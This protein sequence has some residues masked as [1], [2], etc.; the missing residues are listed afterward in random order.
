MVQLWDDSVKRLVRANPQQFF[1]TME[2]LAA[3][4]Q[5]VML[6]GLARVF[7]ELVFMDEADKEWLEKSFAVYKDIVDESWVVQE[8]KAEGEAKGLEKGRIEG[9]IE[10]K[11]E[12][13]IDGL[14]QA[15]L[16]IFQAR[17]PQF[18]VK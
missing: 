11:K 18:D 6:L 16:A 7:A 12:G 1:T 9:R 8:W 5:A 3:T 14:Q 2:K 10:G 4:N 17:F 15:L 13:E